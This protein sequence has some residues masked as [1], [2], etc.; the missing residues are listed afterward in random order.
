M[1]SG[2]PTCGWV[3]S[4][5]STLA[6][7]LGVASA[8][9]QE[10]ERERERESSSSSRKPSNGLERNGFGGNGSTGGKEHSV[11]ATSS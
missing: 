3:L 8:S 9:L 4:I 10:R 7:G 5:E 1:G 2:I 11:K 6:F